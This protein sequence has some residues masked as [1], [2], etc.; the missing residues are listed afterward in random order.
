MLLLDRLAEE[1]I[2]AA[3]RRGDLEDLSG[4]GRPLE[5]EDESA[6]PEELRVA[7]RLLKNAGC[8]PPEFTLR[9]EILRLEGLLMQVESDPESEKLRRRLSLLKARLALGGRE[10]NLLVEESAY[11]EKLLSHLHRA[12]DTSAR[13]G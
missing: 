8:V 1:Q 3:L 9:N 7:Y 13:C 11:R 5:L 6:V 4:T 2:K 12:E 10:P